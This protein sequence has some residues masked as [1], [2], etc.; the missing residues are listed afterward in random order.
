MH[1]GHGEEDVVFL[2]DVGFE[3]GDEPQ[4]DLADLGHGVRLRTGGQKLLHLGFVAPKALVLGQHDGERSRVAW[5]KG[6]Q[7]RKE[8]LL[9]A[10]EMDIQLVLDLLDGLRVA[11]DGTFVGPSGAQRFGE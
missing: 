5:K 3:D 1:L 6:L 11:A 2:L 4:G 7:G 9:F 10:K 8:D